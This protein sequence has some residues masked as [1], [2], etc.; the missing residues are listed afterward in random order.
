[1]KQKLG[2]PRR[3]LG[4][5]VIGTALA[6]AALTASS[7][8]RAG[9]KLAVSQG[10]GAAVLPNTAAFGAT[11]GNTPERVSFVL[12]ANNLANLEAQV[13]AGMPHGFLSVPDF[14]SRYGQSAR[15]IA[16]LEAYLAQYGIASQAMAN[17]LVVQATGTAAQFDSALSVQQQQYHV[18]A[19]AGHNGAPGHPGG[20]AHGTKQ[21][22]LLPRNLAGFV[23]SVLG[24]S[25]W[26][27][28]Q[29]DMIGV[30]KNAQPQDSP[31]TQLM[32][33]DFA[34]RYDLGPVY[35]A[36]GNGH[37]RT[38]G[39]VTLASVD[40]NVVSQFW[41]HAG[42]TGSEASPSRITLDNVD[43]GSGPVNEAFG[44]DETSLDAEQSGALAPGANV[45]VYQAP[46]TD[47]GFV[48]GFFQAASDNVADSVSASWGESETIIQYVQNAGQEDPA[49]VQSFDEAFLELAAQGQSAFASAGDAGAYDA[50][51]DLGATDLSVDN[52]G[53]SPW[54]TSAGGTTLPGPLTFFKSSACPSNAA[55]D[56]TP[57][58]V[59]I[60]I[61]S[62]RAWGWDYLWP[63]LAGHYGGGVDSWAEAEVVGGGGGYSVDEAMPSYQRGVNGTTDF[64]AVDY[65]QPTVP[66]TING[67]TFSTAWNFDPNPPTTYGTGSGRATPDLS[68]DADPETGYE[69]LYTFGDSCLIPSP[70][71]PTP[72]TTPP[73]PSYLQYGGTS[74]VAPQLNGV[75]AAIDSALG[76]RVG[77][78][79]PLIYRFA[80]QRNSPFTPLDTPGTSNDNLYY[81]GTPG[82]VYNVGTGLGTPDLAK[83]A[84]DF[85]MGGRG[86]G[87]HGH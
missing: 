21:T 61:P 64:S 28:M 18:P 25:N 4:L 7:A 78:W 72:C 3:L 33:A 48:D 27:T 84:L 67:Q 19:V 11:P 49:Y 9:G 40:P 74:F 63:V 34:S 36:G 54:I 60:N 57:C 85:E 75:A 29:S 22:P 20:I 83:L 17:N 86:F 68:T 15:N 71:N 50:S 2:T 76:R 24:L 81:S 58:P 41:Q 66:A 44:S 1:M 31:N 23:L 47:N 65:L 52:P 39:I 14:A 80:T 73:P 87:G 5:V 53:D 12:R 38:I 35:A 69:L 6:I 51:R 26:P 79:N 30:P 46:N 45:I 59:T 8:A 77:F 56:T 10:L 55:G 62:E 42:L 70:T 32:P 82:H 37:G 43:G 13:S 16:A